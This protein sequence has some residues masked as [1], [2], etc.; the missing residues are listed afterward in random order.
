MH[1]PLNLAHFREIRGERLFDVDRLFGF[2]GQRNY[3]QTKLLGGGKADDV[4]FRICDGALKIFT[5]VPRAEN[6]PA[7]GEGAIIEIDACVQHHPWR[8][9]DIRDMLRARYGAA[10]YDSEAKRLGFIVRSHSAVLHKVRNARSK[11]RVCE[12]SDPVARSGLV[13]RSGR[14]AS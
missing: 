4:H 3:W 6:I 1:D 8:F 10:A 12:A 7:L 14:T 13:E 5:D 9:H 2:S 11:T